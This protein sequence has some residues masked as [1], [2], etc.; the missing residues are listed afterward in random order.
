[1]V[2]GAG[3]SPGEDAEPPTAD[4]MGRGIFVLDAQTG[5]RVWSAAYTA[6]GTACNGTST[7]AACAVVGMNWAIPADISFV[8]RDNDGKT[9]RLYAAD[10]GG[11]VW[12][13][14]LEPVAGGSGTPDTWR[15]SKLAA[16]GCDTGVC[17]AGTTPRKFFYPPNVLLVGA[18]GATGSYDAVLIGSG[19][20]E[21]PLVD[22]A[23]LQS[24]YN[25]TNRFYM[26]KDTNTGKDATVDMAG[27]PIIE[28]G[29]FNATAVNYNDTLKGY[30]VTL[31]AGEKV[32][33]ASLTV[34][35]TTFFGTNRPVPP[36]P[37]SC[38]S[39]LGEAKGYALNP[40]KGGRTSTIYDGGGLPPTPVA[41]I[42][43]IRI[44]ATQTVQQSFCVGCGG[45]SALGAGG[46]TGGDA[47][48]S[49][50]AVDLNKAIPKKPRRTYWYKR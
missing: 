28:S 47:R 49:L 44:S 5:V 16:L 11:N 35:G 29:L 10:L 17:P 38:V 48:S 46:A 50:G 25:K 23:N 21:H 19:D 4:T 1:L 9:D 34:R 36:N 45:A 24:A 12:R 30:Y 43:S 39:N 7:Q 14:D 40:F 2:F 15:V 6:G 37:A 13:V 22:T 27:Y 33:N 42:V 41:G 8:D 3:Y 32:V 18:T 26:L 31:A 20:R